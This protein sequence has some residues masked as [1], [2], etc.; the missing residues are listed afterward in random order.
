MAL[1]QSVLY[2]VHFMACSIFLIKIVK[3]DIGVVFYE[4]S[5]ISTIFKWE[6]LRVSPV[7]PSVVGHSFL[8]IT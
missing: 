3:Y 4:L 5:H 7:I 8:I 1:G 6:F 2:L